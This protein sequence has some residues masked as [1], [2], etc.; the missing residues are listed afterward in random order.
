MVWLQRDVLLLKIKHMLKHVLKGLSIEYI[1]WGCIFEWAISKWLSY[2][3]RAQHLAS[4]LNKYNHK[5]RKQ[6]K[7]KLSPLLNKLFHCWF[8]PNLHRNTE[9]RASFHSFK[10]LVLTVMGSIEVSGGTPAHSCPQSWQFPCG[11][12]HLQPFLAA[13][14]MWPFPPIPREQWVC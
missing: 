9:A 2:C 5:E 1:I 14:E 10:H 11:M 3:W 13:E 8:V 12:L 4:S 7:Q 6:T